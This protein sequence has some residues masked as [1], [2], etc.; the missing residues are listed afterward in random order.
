MHRFV[1]A[2]MAAATLNAQLEREAAYQHQWPVAWWTGEKKS[3]SGGYHS[4]EEALYRSSHG[5]SRW[6]DALLA[7][8]ILPALRSIAS[9]AS[10]GKTA[11][12]EAQAFT[13]PIRLDDEAALA[14]A[15][16]AARAG[17]GLDADGVPAGGRIT[18][19][20]NVNGPKD[21]NHLHDHGADCAWSL[22]YYVASGEEAEDAG[23]LDFVSCLT[24]RQTPGTGVKATAATP[25]AA[26]GPATASAAQ[27]ALAAGLGGTLLLKTHEDRA[28]GAHSFL[29]V[30]PVPG[31]LWC[32]PGHLLHAVMPRELS[33]GVGGSGSAMLQRGLRTSVACNVYCKSSP[34]RD[35]NIGYRDE[36]ALTGEHE[37]LDDLRSCSISCFAPRK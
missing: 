10:G 32:F 35:A 29:S 8:V 33:N 7:Q 22:V 34:F 25:V 13:E 11:P 28:T 1:T 17:H 12:H 30:T 20:L 14:A 19:W 31:E 21:L 4:R 36:G 18:G 27:P 3:N 5:E 24:D 37:G 23:P 6:Y 16:A 9:D 26:S 2:P 15:A